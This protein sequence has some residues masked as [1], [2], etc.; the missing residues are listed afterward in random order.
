MANRA[1]VG[2]AFMLVALLCAWFGAA[3][4]SPAATPSITLTNSSPNHLVEGPNTGAGISLS[5]GSG[6]YDLRVRV[7]GWDGSDVFQQNIQNVTGGWSDAIQVPLNR[8]GSYE[9]IAEL[10]LPGQ[11]T[12]VGSGQMRLVRPTRVPA[13]SA[14]ERRDSCIG[15]NTHW[16]AE[17]SSLQRI[18]V[19]WARDYSWGWLGDGSVA[20]MAPNGSNFA[21]HWNAANNAGVT[22]LPCMQQVFWNASQTA[23][24][25]D[26]D[27]IADSYE[28]LANAFP[29]IE[30][31]EIDNEAK[32]NF[33]NRNGADPDDY[34]QNYR[35]FIAAVAEGLQRA[36]SAKLVLSGTAGIQLND[37]HALLETEGV[38]PVV[39]DDF[40][41]VNYHHYADGFPPEVAP[42]KPWLDTG[43]VTP[44]DPILE[45]QTQINS[46]AH[47]AGKE[48]W[49]TEVGYGVQY[50]YGVGERLQAAYLAREYLLSRSVGTDKVFWFFDR[51]CG[52]TSWISSMG[53]FEQD[54]WDARPSAAAMAAVSKFTALAEYTGELSPGPFQCFF[55]FRMP[56]DT[57]MAVAWAI[58][59]E[60]AYELPEGVLPPNTM[61]YDM[62]GNSIVPGII[63]P[64]VTYFIFGEPVMGDMNGDGLLNSQD[65]NP[66]ALALTD[67][68]AW[69]AEYPE[70]NFL[71]VGDMNGDGLLNSQDIN[72]FVALLTGGVPVPEPTTV[73]FLGVGGLVVL[74]R[75]R[76]N[77]YRREKAK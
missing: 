47:E 68:A 13:L 30:Y 46:V 53:L 29:Q 32:Y 56:D 11:S 74:L 72:P 73:G 31:W 61:A 54:T 43:W 16:W 77:G 27:Y 9:V 55:M 75:R 60:Y 26:H 48:A 7:V 37:T 57:E 62:F 65:I 24:I 39:R 21:S 71:A 4:T 49:K 63:G 14:E 50:K 1:R 25:E 58:S 34:V 40:D 15:V 23:Y 42:I 3:A 12:V 2:L 20:P 70:V 18:G 6:A 67:Q 64:E 38:S 45:M 22:V 35:G 59:D 36:G 8:Y 66:F 33:V 44:T 5:S 10:R 19:H 76:R 17:W 41:V 69:Q 52:G 28:R 51:D